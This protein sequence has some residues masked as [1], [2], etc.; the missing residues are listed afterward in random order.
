MRKLI[1]TGLVALSMSAAP[2]LAGPASAG[3]GKAAASS[4]VINGDVDMTAKVDNQIALAIGKNAEA[5]AEQAVVYEGTSI[6]GDVDITATAKNQIALAVGVNT[7][8]AARQ[9]VIGAA[10][11]KR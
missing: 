11:P 5:F 6:N 2:A 1:L 8:A 7:H 9:G 10:R 4:V 3:N